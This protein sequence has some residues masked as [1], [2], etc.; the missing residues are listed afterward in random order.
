VGQET[1]D[2]TIASLANGFAAF[3]SG[4]EFA[5]DFKQEQNVPA[6]LSGKKDPRKCQWVILDAKAHVESSC[7][8]GLFF[9]HAAGRTSFLRPLRE[10]L[11]M[12]SRTKRRKKKGL[13]YHRHKRGG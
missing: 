12:D 1:V 3:S 8:D 4:S 7:E 11:Q 2:V 5:W 9:L 6:F 13:D 10:A